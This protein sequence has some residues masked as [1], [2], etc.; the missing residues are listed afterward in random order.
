MA[1]TNADE[2]ELFLNGKSLG[3][4]KRFASRWNCRWATTS[5]ATRKFTSKY[6]LMWQ[7]PYRTGRV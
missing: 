3:R 5:A 7:V 2:V 6:R 4:K 1:Y